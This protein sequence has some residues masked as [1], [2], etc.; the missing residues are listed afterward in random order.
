MDSQFEIKEL[1]HIIDNYDSSLLTLEFSGSSI[2]YSI[3]NSIRKVCINQIPIY[4]FHPS[5]INI[6]RNS[7]VF[8]NSYMK[9]RISQLPIQKINH[10]IKFLSLKYYKDVN[11]LDNKFI[12][13]IDDTFDIDMYLKKKKCWS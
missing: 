6:L 13:H 9:E 5:K 3:I 7:S 12:R 1:D 2:N 10:E 11:F 8:D 4:G